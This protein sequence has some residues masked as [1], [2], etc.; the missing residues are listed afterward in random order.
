MILVSVEKTNQERK[1]H[2]TLHLIILYH[3]NL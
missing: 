3:T 1:L 2:K